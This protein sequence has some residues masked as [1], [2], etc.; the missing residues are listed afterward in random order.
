VQ[1][2]RAGIELGAS[3][4]EKRGE[5]ESRR[6]CL[7]HGFF[8]LVGWRVARSEPHRPAPVV[9]QSY[10]AAEGLQSGNQL[11]VSRILGNALRVGL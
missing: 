3:R 5:V 4:R 6:W 7:P 2:H 9:H 1:S 8:D 11:G 10:L